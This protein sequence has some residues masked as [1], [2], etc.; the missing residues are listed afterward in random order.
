MEDILLLPF[1]L[2]KKLRG[3][4][5]SLL[6]PLGPQSPGLVL[7]SAPTPCPSPMEYHLFFMHPAGTRLAH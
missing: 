4:F 6:V 7:G 3:K 2:K 1:K 5:H